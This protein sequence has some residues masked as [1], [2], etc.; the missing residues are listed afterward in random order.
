MVLPEAEGPV[1]R[2]MEGMGLAG[3]GTRF[4][5]LR[6]RGCL[7]KLCGAERFFVPV[8]YNGSLR[9]TRR[10]GER[11]ELRSQGTLLRGLRRASRL[12]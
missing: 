12:G 8:E 2:R 4:V 6:K 1:R 11:N 10:G 9:M 3:L 5:L 7:S